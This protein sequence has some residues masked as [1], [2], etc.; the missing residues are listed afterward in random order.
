MSYLVSIAAVIWTIRSPRLA[1]V[2]RNW[3][4][5]RLYWVIV[6]VIVA[7]FCLVI[8]SYLSDKT[9]VDTPVLW[10]PFSQ[11]ASLSHNLRISGGYK[12]D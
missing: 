4:V 12:S 9:L 2:M 8:F 7:D 11:L 5:F 1:F 3:E 6:V 10:V